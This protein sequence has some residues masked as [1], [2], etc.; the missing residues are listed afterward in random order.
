MMKILFVNMFYYPT[1][2][3]GTE[4]SLKLLAEEL[5]DRGHR[6]SV[7]TYDGK[8]S[9]LSQECINGVFIYRMCN[10]LFMKKFFHKSISTDR[11]MRY[12]AGKYFNQSVEKQ[13]KRI[14]EQVQPDIVHTQNFF[15]TALLK[16]VKKR[17]ISTVHTLRDYFMLDPKSNLNAS[18]KMIVVLHRLYQRFYLDRYLDV[19]TAPSEIILKRHVE[20]DF[21]KTCR[22]KVIHNAVRLNIEETSCYIEGKKNRTDKTVHFL[23]AGRLVKLKG[24]DLL[25][26]TFR[27]IR[28]DHIRLTVCGSG[29]LQDD[30]EQVCAQDTRICYKGQLSATDLSKEYVAADVV[31][32]PSLWEEPFGRIV[33]EAAQ[34]GNP[35]IGSNRG[36]VTEIIKHSGFGSVFAYDDA[37]DLQRQIRLF[38]DRNY[39]RQFYPQLIGG[40]QEFSSKKQVEKFEDV[41]R[42]VRGM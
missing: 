27:E 16:C 6:V 42:E 23:Y 8:E 2:I 29:P 4:H 17:G 14:L 37:E 41:Y 7:A 24:I 22:T 18:P 9:G 5:T 35:V 32:V 26:T 25:L 12:Y 19:V 13:L 31:I 33:I 21:F 15:P 20:R 34:Y 39:L 1:M 28:L 3:G 36:G 38:A 11:K 40:I 10:M 30:V